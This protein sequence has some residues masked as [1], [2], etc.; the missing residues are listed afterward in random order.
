LLLTSGAEAQQLLTASNELG[1][2]PDVFMP[3]VLAG[4]DVAAA[5]PAVRER[6]YLAFPTLRA[7]HKPDGCQEYLAM[8]RRHDLPPDLLSTRTAA[9]ASA[10]LLVE[11]LRRCGRDIRREKAVTVLDGMTEFQTGLTP[12]LRFS[13]NRRIGAYGA[14]VARP[15][16]PGGAFVP[17]GGWRELSD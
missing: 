4:A 17:V 5:P 12:P 3:A 2:R 15:T 14:Y 8:A 1:W 9:L 16:G 10:K 11:T 6:L 7:D 13:P